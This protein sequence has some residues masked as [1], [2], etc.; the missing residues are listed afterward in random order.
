MPSL[1]GTRADLQEGTGEG[2]GHARGGRGDRLVLV[3]VRDLMFLSKIRETLK[4]L[5]FQ[6]RSLGAHQSLEGLGA[7]AVALFIADASDAGLDAVEA[8]GRAKARGIPVLAFGSHVDLAA[9]DA[10]RSAGADE[11]V[12]RSVFSSNLAGLVR[13]FALPESAS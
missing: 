4:A 7:D 1:E 9:L 13:A 5:G 11:V 2:V 6:A 3:L 10:A 12:P 8:I